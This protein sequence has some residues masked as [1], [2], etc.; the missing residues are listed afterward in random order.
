MQ[1][2]LRSDRTFGEEPA[3]RKPG[4]HAKRVKRIERTFGSKQ[5]IEVMCPINTG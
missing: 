5:L 1:P 2:F 4:K 3:L